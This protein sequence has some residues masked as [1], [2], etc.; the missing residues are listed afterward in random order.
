MFNIEVNFNNQRK[1]V[2]ARAILPSYIELS[3][4]F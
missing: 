1:R 3:P 4:Q 2:C